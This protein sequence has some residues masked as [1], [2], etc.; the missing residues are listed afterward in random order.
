M[1]GRNDRGMASRR[2]ASFARPALVRILAILVVLQGFAA[3]FPSHAH[4][5]RGG[6]VTIA[7]SPT[8]ALCASDAQGD[9]HSPGHMHDGAQCC[10]LCEARN[11]SETAVAVFALIVVS[12]ARTPSFSTA[13]YVVDTHVKPPA[14]WASAWSSRAPPF[15]S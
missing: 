15:F 3:L 6:E 12:I 1:I 2:Q 10:I 7:L 5:G 14:G 4:I 11:Q 9:H 8:E 13:A